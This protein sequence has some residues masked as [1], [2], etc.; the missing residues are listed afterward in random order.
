[1]IRQVIMKTEIPISAIV[2]ILTT[3]ALV[4]HT[5][6][7]A[8]AAEKFKDAAATA[9]LTQDGLS[10]LSVEE[11][12]EKWR[13]KVEDKSTENLTIKVFWRGKN[14]VLEVLWRN[15]W[16]GTRSNMFSATVYD[17]QTKIGKIVG[18]PGEAVI[19]QPKEARVAYNVSTVIKDNGRV[20]L[21]TSNESGYFQVIEVEGRRTRPM[22]DIE[23]TK[24]AVGVGQILP[25]LWEAIDEL[26]KQPKEE[27]GAHDER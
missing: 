13:T 23:F 7:G 22:D 25:P 12:P 9:A 17:H 3:L 18:L 21:M 4:P 20:L 5:S 6:G 2:L 14:K 11:V 15:D 27:P 19:T 24:M 8:E 26:R 10:T 1:M 16:T